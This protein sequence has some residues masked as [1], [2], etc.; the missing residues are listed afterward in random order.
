MGRLRAPAH[1]ER[2]CSP[3]GIFPDAFEP[4]LGLL[5]PFPS[6]IWA[7]AVEGVGELIRGECKHGHASGTPAS[8]NS[9]LSAKS[10]SLELDLGWDPL[11]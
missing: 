7:G 3:C 5:C 9:K 2:G 6:Q 10:A 11:L 4:P 1:V 8:R